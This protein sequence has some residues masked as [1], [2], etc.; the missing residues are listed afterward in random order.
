MSRTGGIDSARPSKKSRSAHQSGKTTADLEY[1]STTTRALTELVFRKVRSAGQV[2]V[3]CALEAHRIAT[4]SRRPRRTAV[5]LSGLQAVGGGVP[6]LRS[7]KP[8]LR[9]G[10]R[11]AGESAAKTR[12]DKALPGDATRAAEASR[13][14]TPVSKAPTAAGARARKRDASGFRRG[15]RQ[16]H[17]GGR[18]AAR[19]PNR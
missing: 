3:R 8:V 2:S 14:P 5:L 6:G 10:V 12:S 4:N 9:T 7:W 17:G 18:S 15:G 11:R 13:A 19:A 16:V 1:P